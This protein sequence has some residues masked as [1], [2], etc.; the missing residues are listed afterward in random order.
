MYFASECFS[1]KCPKCNHRNE[2][3]ADDE[4]DY[5]VIETCEKCGAKVQVSYH[6]SVS[7]DI[8]V[9][10]PVLMEDDG[11]EMDLAMTEYLRDVPGQMG[12]FGEVVV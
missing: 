10:P 4:G 9:D 11:E 2:M 8:D 1:W 5:E 12:L 6:V 3:E 7:V